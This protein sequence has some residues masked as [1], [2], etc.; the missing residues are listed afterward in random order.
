MDKKFNKVKAFVKKHKKALIITGTV[1]IGGTICVMMKR[2]P[3]QVVI[4][5]TK[6]KLPKELVV[7]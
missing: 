7:P 3:T 5:D 1:I 4:T 2:K 6:P